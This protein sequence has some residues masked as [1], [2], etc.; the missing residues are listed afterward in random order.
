MPQVQ[1]AR[2]DAPLPCG[3]AI[4]DPPLV[5]CLKKVPPA[6]YCVEQKNYVSQG[7]EMVDLS[8]FAPSDCPAGLVCCVVLDPMP[9]IM[10]R[11]EAD[12]PGDGVST[13][14]V[15]STAADCPRVNMSCLP[16]DTGAVDGG[17][18]VPPFNVCF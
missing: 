18:Q 6:A 2:S 1:D 14:R 7:C 3:T 8:C 17:G 13:D 16:V 11:Q 10:C 15:C 5:C 9:G 4:C 12:C